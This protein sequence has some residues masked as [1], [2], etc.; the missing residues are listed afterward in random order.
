MVRWLHQ[1]HPEARHQLSASAWRHRV[2]AKYVLTAYRFYETP[3]V[4]LLVGKSEKPFYIHLNL[5][6]DASSF[7]RAAFT[8][9]FKESSEEMMKLPEDDESIFSL[10]IDWL[11]H[12]RYEMLPEQDHDDSDDDDDNADDDNVEYEGCEGDRFHQAFQLF[13][14]AEK[15]DVSNLKSLIIERLFAE[16]S[17]CIWSPSDA[18]IAYLYAHTTRSSGIR[19]LVADWCAW[20]L[21]PRW[22]ER[23]R[24]QAFLR[25][26]PEFSTDV[27]VSFGK[28]LDQG[29]DYN[30]F[31][32]K[33]PKEY[34]DM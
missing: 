33:T 30:P 20:R 14:L 27:I 2:F 10:F 16:G 29:P 28:N 23:R 6:C 12:Q 17:V 9:D 21:H 26:Q 25:R 7:F 24:N 8:G 31:E 15:Y 22:F 11:Y 18:S 4:T 1:R 32:R 34:K 5:L 3:T 19:R 13:V